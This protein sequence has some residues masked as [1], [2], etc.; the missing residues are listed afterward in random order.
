M[1]EKLHLV[2]EHL[3]VPE[4]PGLVVR[5]RSLLRCCPSNQDLS[6]VLV[7]GSWE[8]PNQQRLF[9]SRTNIAVSRLIRKMK[10]PGREN[11]ITVI[12]GTVTDDVRI[13]DIPKLKICASSTKAVAKSINVEQCHKPRK[14]Q[15]SNFIKWTSPGP[16]IFNTIVYPHV[17]NLFFTGITAHLV[18]SSELLHHSKH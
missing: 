1:L 5:V 9:M 3:K 17:H 4:R 7:A 8:H 2:W 18:I 14:P 11:K 10:L 15:K 12:V 13:Q 6:L 16:V